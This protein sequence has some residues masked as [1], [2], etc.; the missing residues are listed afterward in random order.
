MKTALLTG[1]FLL[2]ALTNL[3]TAQTDRHYVRIVVLD[4]YSLKESQ[5]IDLYIRTKIGVLTSRMDRQT[6]LYLGIFNTNE[7]LSSQDFIIWI[8]ELGFTTKCMVEGVHGT[9]EPIKVLDRSEC[10]QESKLTE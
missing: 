8:E 5:Q 3:C 10:I 7:G 6:G 9:E 2:M 1:A 4:A